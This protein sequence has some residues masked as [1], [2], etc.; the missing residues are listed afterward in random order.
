MKVSVVGTRKWEKRLRI[1]V[2][3][4]QRSVSWRKQ[5]IANVTGYRGINF[6]NDY[7]E[8]DEEKRRWLLQE[9]KWNNENPSAEKIKAN[10]QLR[11]HSP[12]D[13]SVGKKQIPSFICGFKIS[14]VS[15]WI[16]LW[17][18]LRNRQWWTV[19]KQLSKCLSSLAA[20]SVL[21]ISKRR[22]YTC[23]KRRALII[24]DE[25]KNTYFCWLL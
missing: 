2:Q 24:E 11:L 21:V 12:I 25:F 4:K 18:G 6:L 10:K 15:S 13:G 7:D 23:C 5:H 17:W 1:I 8:A 22:Q 20:R 16:Q 19:V 9:A 14:K 3:E